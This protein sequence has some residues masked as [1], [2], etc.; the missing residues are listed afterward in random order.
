MLIETANTSPPVLGVITMEPSESSEKYPII[1]ST[2][3]LSVNVFSERSPFGLS[4]VIVTEM[5]LAD[6]L[7]VAEDCV[8][9]DDEDD[10]DA[11]FWGQ[12]D[13]FLFSEGAKGSTSLLSGIELEFDEVECMGSPRELA[14]AL[15]LAL[16]LVSAQAVNIKDKSKIKREILIFIS[17]F[18]IL[19]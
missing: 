5:E 12:S 8:G 15:S 10:F 3:S 16:V 11:A 17:S 4:H 9:A 13:S 14:N 18:F 2:V 1:A 7:S 6:T 19:L